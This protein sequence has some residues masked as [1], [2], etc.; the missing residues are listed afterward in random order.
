[1]EAIETT[2]SPVVQLFPVFSDQLLNEVQEFD[3]HILLSGFGGD[4]CVSYNARGILNE[5]ASKEEWKEVLLAI[6]GKTPLKRMVILGKLF[7]EHR[8]INHS[9]FLKK[10]VRNRTTRYKISDLAMDSA[11]QRSY[12][13]IEQEWKDS[14]NVV[15][16][17][18]REQQ[19]LKLM[20]E[21][22]SDRLENSY[23]LAQ[24]RKI[25]YAY[26]LLDIKLLAFVY[27]LPSG[28]K[29]KDGLGRYLMR[30]A[31]EGLLPEDVRMRTSKSGAAVPNIF[32]RFHMD[33]DQYFKLIDEAEERNNFHYLNYKKLRWQIGKLMDQK[34]FLQLSFGPR[35]FFSSISLLILQKWK[36]EGKMNTGIKC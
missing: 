13:K 4:E 14:R 5:Y 9:E 3:L 34:N 16:Y 18:I 30:R 10:L 1:M 15:N 35:I 8:V 17:R 6:R 28:F 11:F 32:Y 36:R 33:R 25:E 29:H 7:L 23:L 2:Q 24:K 19:R 22:V 12:K 31:M 26:P 20:H 27:S 21:S